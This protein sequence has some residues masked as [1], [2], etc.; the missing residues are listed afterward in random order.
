M[1]L[2]ERDGGWEGQWKLTVR[3]PRDM[4][5][6]NLVMLIGHTILGEMYFLSPIEKQEEVEVGWALP[7]ISEEFSSSSVGKWSVE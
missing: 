7:L 5:P 1:T 3:R 6:T 2:K 4:V